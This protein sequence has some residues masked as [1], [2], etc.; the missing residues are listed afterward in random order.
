[1]VQKNEYKRPESVLVV[2][3]AQDQVL[4]LQRRD[5]PAFWQSVT[6]SMRFDEENPLQSAWRELAEETG[7]LS[8]QG[9][10]QDCHHQT[11]FDIYPHW[12]FRYSPDVTKNLEHVFCFRMEK[13]V[14]IKLSKEHLDYCWV[15]KEEAVKLVFS[16]TNREAILQFVV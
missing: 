6:G 5:D 11:W 16:T 8:T 9:E 7:L 4:L 10:M 3:F 2:I 15:T 14:N 12:R 13:P 1:M